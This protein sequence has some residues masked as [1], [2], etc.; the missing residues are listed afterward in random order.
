MPKPRIYPIGSRHKLCHWVDKANHDKL[1]SNLG[2]IGF[3]T[4]SELINH[5]LANY[6][7]RIYRH[8]W[9]KERDQ[10]GR[11]NLEDIGGNK[12]G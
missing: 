6:A 3:K 12:T 10:N 1:A 7:K 8:Y 4:M 2:V 9:R 5:T 11:P